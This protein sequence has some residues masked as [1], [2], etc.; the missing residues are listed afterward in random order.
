MNAFLAFTI[1]VFLAMAI[2]CV[3]FFTDE[4]ENADLRVLAALLCCLCLGIA[5]WAIW[6][7]CTNGAALL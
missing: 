6:L 3:V 2:T 4:H 7:F 1:L 5:S